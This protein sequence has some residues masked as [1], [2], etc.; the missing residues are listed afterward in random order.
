VIRQPVFAVCAALI[1][2]ALVVVDLHFLF[3]IDLRPTVVLLTSCTI[4]LWIVAGWP[5]W[6]SEPSWVDRAGRVAGVGWIIASF[7]V[8]VVY[9]MG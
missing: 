1:V 6:R 5:P 4:M 2:G 7:L 3:G 8:S 9:W